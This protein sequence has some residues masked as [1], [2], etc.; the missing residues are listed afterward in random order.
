MGLLRL[1]GPLVTTD[2]VVQCLN[3]GHELTAVEHLR[4]YSS[5]M[6]ILDCFILDL[7]EEL[8]RS[9]VCSQSLRLLHRYQQSK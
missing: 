6:L 3:G 9:E 4:L 1:S 7:A 5:P 8:Q 2:I